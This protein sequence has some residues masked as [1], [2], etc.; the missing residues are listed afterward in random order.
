MLKEAVEARA[1]LARLDE[2][3]GLIPNPAALINASPLLEAQAS[4]EIENI[5]T[6][7]DALFRHAG[8][9]GDAAQ[10]DPATNRPR[11]H[12]RH[13]TVQSN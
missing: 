12:P 7:T 3:T 8:D 13:L 9:A 5:V 10:A 2:A 1:A 6:T 4:W 11:V